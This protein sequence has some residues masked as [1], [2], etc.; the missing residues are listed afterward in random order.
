[1][2]QAQD[3]GPSDADQAGRGGRRGG[4]PCGRGADLPGHGAPGRECRRRSRQGD[5]RRAV[6]KLQ[7]VRRG[8]GLHLA[9]RG[10]A[11]LLQD[12]GRGRRLDHRRP[13]HGRR[14]EGSPP[15]PQGPPDLRAR[16][17]RRHHLPRRRRERGHGRAAAGGRRHPGAD[18]GA[19]LC[20]AHATQLGHGAAEDGLLRGE[21]VSGAGDT[22]V[23]CWP[24]PLLG[25]SRG[26]SGFC[27]G[28]CLVRRPSL[29]A[30]RWGYLLL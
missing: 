4:G 14:R 24:P 6:P 22:A 12:P 23:A 29:A 3:C 20:E 21:E 11:R 10:V 19:A 13:H 1:M 5:L 28:R 26:E 27:R 30:G 8:R 2:L 15:S 16:G 7:G 9:L 17:G 18:V 25:R